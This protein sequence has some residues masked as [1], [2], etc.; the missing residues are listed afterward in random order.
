VCVYSLVKVLQETR[1]VFSVGSFVVLDVWSGVGWFSFM[2]LHSVEDAM[3]FC[4]LYFLSHLPA[5]F[6][7]EHHAL[8]LLRVC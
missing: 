6:S 5:W 7:G 8:G 2:N 1:D 3:W 4:L